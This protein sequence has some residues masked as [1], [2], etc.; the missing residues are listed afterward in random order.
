MRLAFFLLFVGLAWQCS[1]QTY[2]TGGN[3]S[4]IWSH[5]MSPYIVTG[6]II[7][8]DNQTLTIEPGVTIRFSSS[9]KLQVLGQITSIGT[10][11]DSIVFTSQDITTGW[12]GISIDNSSTGGNGTMNDNDSSIFV[13][14]RIEYVKGNLSNPFWV[15]EFNK[16]RIENCEISNN[17]SNQTISTGNTD[18][19]IKYCNIHHN[20]VN[21]TTSM[22]GG[23][24]I[25][26][27][28]PTIQNNTITHN[29]GKWASG[30]LCNGCGANISGNIVAYNT[31]G[32]YPNSSGAGIICWYS[33]A[34][35]HPIITNN[36][37]CYNINLY[38]NQLSTSGLYVLGSAIVANNIVYGN[39]S[40]SG[41]KN[42]YVFGTARFYNNAIE[43]FPTG[44]YGGGAIYVDNIKLTSIP[45]ISPTNFNISAS[46]VCVNNGKADT[47][48][49]L[50]PNKDI[51]QNPRIYNNRI[52][53]GAYE[54]QPYTTNFVFQN[55]CQFLV[56]Q[57]II[58]NV[59]VIQS[60]IWNFGDS[61]T[62]TQLNPTHIYSNAGI[63]TVTLNATFT[64][65][66]QQTVTK[67]ITINPKPIN[68]IITH[69]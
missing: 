39:I 44:G 27:G 32:N 54:Y 57:F 1:S 65:G 69:K 38:A 40:S 17:S 62:S 50:L 64:N 10:F 20:N 5:D 11:T 24:S 55:T 19:I 29:F 14:T 3:V 9:A 28:K 26:Q 63:F 21:S 2:I 25:A 13:Y 37:I 51:T 30:I 16:V 67:Q 45:Y 60:V 34:G 68:L 8:P 35:F 6:T 33:G 41:T 22:Y 48:G 12:K 15:S 47:T 42:V 53:I 66:Q 43:N 61:Q 46:S 36:T 52:D 49:L 58:T 18:I 7:I 23:I 4:G 31:R 59:N 56:T